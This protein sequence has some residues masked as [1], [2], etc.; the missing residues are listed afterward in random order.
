MFRVQG[1]RGTRDPLRPHAGAPIASP[2]GLERLAGWLIGAV[3]WKI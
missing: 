1:M 3:L 2:L